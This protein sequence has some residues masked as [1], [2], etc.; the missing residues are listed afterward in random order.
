MSQLSERFVR[1]LKL[2]GLCQSTVESYEWHVRRFFV[3]A[4]IKDPE[5]VTIETI[6]QY[7]LELLEKRNWAAS[8]VNCRISALRRFFLDTLGKKWDRKAF[9]FV[10]KRRKV[11]VILSLD[12]VAR[13]L[14]AVKDLKHRTMLLAVY[15]GGLRCCEVLRLR[16]QDIQSDR[17]MMYVAFGKGGKTRYT[18]LPTVLLHALRYYWKSTPEVDKSHWLFPSHV[19][20][21]QPIHDA[22]LRAAFREA[23]K[24]S[25][26]KR[27]ISL[28][29]LRHCF[30][31]HLLESGVDLSY[32]Q[33]L[34]GHTQI[35][36]TMI[37]SIVRDSQF[38][39]I[40]SP[41][42]VIGQKLS[43]IPSSQLNRLAAQAA[44]EDPKKKKDAA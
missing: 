38:Q 22:T 10:K 1:D 35:S 18:L 41:L 36:T 34:L 5:A 43:W 11:P 21:Q 3:E 15:G 2:R 9:P 12:E 28:H 14:M 33:K 30:A 42:G 8:T 7:Q 37:Y 32:I 24:K 19:N 4:R 17:S 39:V 26:I 16:A 27:Q 29:G 13:L 31:T 25:G 6:L 44:P 23:L 20:T 40:T